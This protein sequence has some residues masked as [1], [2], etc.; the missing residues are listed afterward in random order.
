MRKKAIIHI[1]D[2]HVM[3]PTFRNLEPKKEIKSWFNTNNN[4]LDVERYLDKFIEIIKSTYDEDYDF[5]ILVTGDI[6]DEAQD[7]EFSKATEIINRLKSELNVNNDNLLIVPGD[8]DVNWRDCEN[9]FE[10]DDRQK[11]SYLYKEKYNR[12]S[13]FYKEIYETDFDYE[14]VILKEIIIENIVF[15]GMNSNYKIDFCGGNGFIKKKQLIEELSQI[16]EKYNGYSKIAVFH[17]NITPFYQNNTNGQWDK[18]NRIE[19]LEV[20]K[21]FQFK[22]VMFGN[23]HTTGSKEE[24]QFY[25]VG[26]GSLGMKLLTDKDAPPSFKVYNVFEDNSHYSLEQNLFHLINSNK[27]NSTSFGKWGIQNLIQL[28]EI[29]EI[30]LIQKP[31]IEATETN[32]IGDKEISIEAENSKQNI[33]KK[34][35]YPYQNYL[36]NKYHHKIFS[37]VKELKIFHSGHFHWSDNSKAHNWIEVAKLLNDKEDVLLCKKAIL[38]IVEK[39]EIEFDFIIG[40]GIEGNILA[41]RTAIVK[42]K[43][44][45]FLPYS[46]RYEDH[47]DYEQ[48]LSIKN[49]GFEK[50]LIITDVVHDGNTIRNLINDKEPLFFDKSKVKEIHVIS[51]F[52][53]G[54]DEYELGLINMTQEKKEKEKD[55][56][57][58]KH[59]HQPI[60]ERIQFYF[61]SKMIVETCPYGS[62]F[63]ETCMIVKHKLDCVHEFYDA[64]K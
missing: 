25:Y 56:N 11:K 1:S 19:V 4:D 16:K 15:I 51:L 37:R 30:I 57:N 21:S 29:N 42:N 5:S 63:R 61:V 46:Y 10:S 23:E 36:D 38:D 7:E 58:L 12:F 53:S 35:N 62:D 45:S 17:H 31:K 13:N 24:D 54:K 8:H 32:I 60:E 41:T 55:K 22:V 28:D 52:Y 50:I 9:A 39:S 64:N 40:L 18:D 47:A 43:P 6:T 27:N 59:Q 34:E 49:N 48:R 3:L 2:L 20:L 14:K 33:P 26:A 44:Y